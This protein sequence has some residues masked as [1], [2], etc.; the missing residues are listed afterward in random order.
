M[1]SDD[2]YYPEPG[3]RSSCILSTSSCRFCGTLSHTNLT[4]RERESAMRKC[5]Q[6]LICVLNMSMIHAQFQLAHDALSHEAVIVGRALWLTITPVTGSFYCSLTSSSEWHK[7]NCAV[8]DGLRRHYKAQWM[9][10][11]GLARIFCLRN[12]K[13]CCWIAIKHWWQN[14]IFFTHSSLRLTKYH[15]RDIFSIDFNTLF[16]V[17]ISKLLYLYIKGKWSRKMQLFF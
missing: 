16:E 13:K 5:V 1:A 12:V 7:E 3:P 14:L 10:F 15:I 11:P 2:T 9:A 6:L 17:C 4:E 8:L